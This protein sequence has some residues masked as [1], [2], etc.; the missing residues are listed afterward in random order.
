MTVD[1]TPRDGS[2][3]VVVAF[4]GIEAWKST[5]Q[6]RIYDVDNHLLNQGEP[7]KISLRSGETQERAW[8]FSLVPKQ[9]IYRA[10][11]LVGEEVAWREY[12]RISE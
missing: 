5:A 12:F 2:A 8:N 7:V 6:L 11:V 9:G 10:D 1:F 3:T 4:Q